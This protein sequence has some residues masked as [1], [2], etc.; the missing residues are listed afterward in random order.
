MGDVGW[1]D[2]DGFFYIEGCYKDV[3]VYGGDN[4]YSD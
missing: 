2:E 1:L 4:I 3:I